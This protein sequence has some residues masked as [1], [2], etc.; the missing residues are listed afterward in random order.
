MAHRERPPFVSVIIP[1]YRDRTLLMQCL[2]ALSRQ[3]YPTDSFEI[4]VVDNGGKLPL[5]TGV[6]LVRETRPGSY[7]ARNAGIAAARGVIFAFTDADCVPDEWWLAGGVAAMVSE[8]RPDAI[9]GRIDLV[10]RNPTCPR[11]SELFDEIFLGF[12]QERFIREE[13]FAAT[14]N[15]FVWKKTLDKVGTF[16]AA[17]LS[18]GE[19]E[20]GRRLL[21]AGLKL[22]YAPGARVT[23]PS[24]HRLRALTVKVRK[25]V[26]GDHQLSADK[27]W[28]WTLSGG[29]AELRRIR[30]MWREA[31]TSNPRFRLLIA[32]VQF[33]RA[34]ERLRL[35][36]GSTPQR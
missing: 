12:P 33:V 24:R 16:N 34:V 11:A 30:K 7:A 21:A 5:L 35:R 19:V 23:H 18:G 36:L 15:L 25:V 31:G 4:I 1:F 27:G 32:F 3:T 9:G 29:W 26:G 28:R 2:E 6:K 14:A 10:H 20:W 17:L 13:R 8:S 22:E